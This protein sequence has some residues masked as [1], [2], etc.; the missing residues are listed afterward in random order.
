ML[1]RIIERVDSFLNEEN[2]Q[3][4]KVVNVRSI[5]RLTKD[6]VLH[7]FCDLLKIFSKSAKFRNV[8]YF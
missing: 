4:L 2:H 7:L 1:K 6:T 8:D 3:V 5:D